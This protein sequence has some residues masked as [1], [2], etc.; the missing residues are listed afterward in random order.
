MSLLFTI[1][2]VL[3]HEHDRHRTLRNKRL[4]ARFMRRCCADASESQFGLYVTRKHQRLAAARDSETA[5]MMDHAD[6]VG[7]GGGGGGDS[8]GGSLG[9]SA[10]ESPRASPLLN[11]RGIGL[12]LSSSAA[13]SGGGG[14][15]G[16]ASPRSAVAAGADPGSEAVSAALRAGEPELSPEQQPRQLPLPTATSSAAAAASVQQASPRKPEPSIKISGWSDDEKSDG[17]R[18]PR[19]RN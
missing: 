3:T 17:K 19:G 15:S 1:R 7:L 4:V 9:G 13:A 12:A 16:P 2:S 14:S 8:N 5:S 18:R 11:D 6:G 10:P